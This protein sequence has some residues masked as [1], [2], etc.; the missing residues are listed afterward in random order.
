M[1]SNPLLNYYRQPGIQIDL[2]SKGEYYGHH[3]E[4]SADNKIDI[5]P[6]TAS[7]SI[8]INNPDGLING[9]SIEQ[10]IKSC[11]PAITH[12]LDLSV[13]D[14]DVILLAIKLVSFGQNLDL[15]GVCPKCGH[16]NKITFD[17]RNLLSQCKDLPE[18]EAIRLTDELVAYIRPYSFK[19][20]VLL[21]IKEFEEA[22][23]LSTLTEEEANLGE[24]EK[25]DAV[26]DSLKR[27][28][29]L[30]LS[31]LYQSVMKICTPGGEVT[32]SNFIKDFLN[33]T[34]TQIVHKI[35]EKQEALNQYGMPKSQ[36]ATCTN[37]SCHHTWDLPIVYDP[38]S[39]FA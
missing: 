1:T 33:N 19:T 3:I 20:S 37:E 9:S 2:P 23:L 25:I 5:Y 18:P 17:I 6:M 10:V 36:K 39:F 22:R 8:V 35:Q 26:A 32:D 29:E 12:P 13:V 16:E 30:S 7:D 15:V 34:T 38:S 21:N 11:C 28:N 27:I 31:L 4:T 14:I 24:K